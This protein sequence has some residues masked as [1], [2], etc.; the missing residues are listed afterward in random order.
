MPS[1]ASFNPSGLCITDV[2]SLNII[3]FSGKSGMLL[4]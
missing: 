3:P 1:I 2:I 4:T